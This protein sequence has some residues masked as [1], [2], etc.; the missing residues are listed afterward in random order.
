MDG[1]RKVRSE[2]EF[3]NQESPKAIE[4]RTTGA[5]KKQRTVHRR[6]AVLRITSHRN[7]QRLALD[8][9]PVATTLRAWKSITA[10]RPSQ[11][12][13]RQVRKGEKKG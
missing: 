2:K 7:P 12:G 1:M 10:W 8:A 11:R 3:G 4:N 13:D 9:G 5:I 6:G